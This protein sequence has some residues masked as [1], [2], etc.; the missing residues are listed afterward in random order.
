MKFYIDKDGDLGFSLNGKDAHVMMT[1]SAVDDDW[2]WD[3]VIQ[4]Q[5]EALTEDYEE[6]IY[7]G[8][9]TELS[10]C[11]SGPLTEV[12]EDQAKDLYRNLGGKV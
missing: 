2:S 4:N 9:I 6:L 12:T 10:E 7:L 8:G 3:Y 11:P 5:T 1:Q